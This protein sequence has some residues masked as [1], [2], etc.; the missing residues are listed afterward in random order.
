MLVKMACKDLRGKGMP[1]KKMFNMTIPILGH[2]F[3]FLPN[4]KFHD[5]YVENEQLSLSS[6]CLLSHLDLKNVKRILLY[7]DVNGRSIWVDHRVS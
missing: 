6:I 2:L 5:S 3:V 4:F 1:D 7:M